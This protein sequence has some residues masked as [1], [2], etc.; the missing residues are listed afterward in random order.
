MEIQ[1]TEIS[2]DESEKDWELPAYGT[3]GTVTVEII[4]KID[5]PYHPGWEWEIDR[6]SYDGDASTFWLNEGIGIDYWINC[7]VLDAIPGPGIWTFEGVV[8]HYYKGDWGFTDDD[9]EWDY[10]TIRLATQDEI[11]NL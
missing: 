8:G 3:K 2:V 5:I 7:M 1:A 6:Y 9:E 10:D 4:G 11:N